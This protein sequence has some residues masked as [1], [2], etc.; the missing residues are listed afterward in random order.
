[1]GDYSSAYEAKVGRALRGL[2]EAG[3]IGPAG[4]MV[5]EVEIDTS[6][7]LLMALQ[8]KKNQ[9]STVEELANQIDRSPKT[10]QNTLEELSAAGYNVYSDNGNV[11]LTEEDPLREATQQENTEGIIRFGVISDTHLGAKAERLDVLG[12]L[13]R[14]YESEGVTTVY[15]AG[16]WIEGESRH[17]IRERHIH[18]LDNQ[19]NYFLDNYPSINGLTTKYIAGDDHEG[20]YQQREGISIGRYVESRARERGRTDLEYLGY[21]EHDIEYK[22]SAGTMSVRIAHPG[23]GSAY[24]LS[25]TPQKIVESYSPGEKPDVLIIGHYHKL[26][27]IPAVR[28]VRV[29]QAGCTVDQGTWARKK[30]LAYHLGGWILEL[31][32]DPDTGNCRRCATQDRTY[33]RVLNRNW[34]E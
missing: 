6:K 1:L 34:E 33:Q 4:S 32:Q 26:E 27:Y 16:N 3:E 14:W 30:R 7:L 13:Y 12:D 15:H 10:V 31:E 24:A 23:G 25:Y 28:G 21:L 19:V 17:N 29:I 9:I 11:S 5:E 2:R 18:G 8:K 22:N 20:W